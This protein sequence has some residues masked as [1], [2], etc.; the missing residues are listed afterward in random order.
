MLP[1]LETIRDTP[2]W[3]LGTIGG[4]FLFLRLWL[5]VLKVEKWGNEK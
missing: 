2:I 1:I 3:F 4:I 5:D